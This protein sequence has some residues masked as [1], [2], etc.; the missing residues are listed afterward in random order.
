M[1]YPAS[2][3]TRTAQRTLSGRVSRLAVGA[4]LAT[5][6]TGAAACDDGA[7]VPEPTTEVQATIQ[8]IEAP[9]T[10]Q[11]D[12]TLTFTVRG[13]AGP[14]LCYDFTRLEESRTDGR[15]TMT[16]IATRTGDDDTACAQT[17]S[18]FEVTAD[19][20]PPFEDG[21]FELAV[22]QDGDTDVLDQVEVR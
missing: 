14:N 5:F 3:L 7:I 22:Q 13:I 17:I 10:V 18:T 2:T 21:T 20:A 4:A 16:A 1:K 9:A 8:E 15:L 19:A 6:L 12:E 11:S